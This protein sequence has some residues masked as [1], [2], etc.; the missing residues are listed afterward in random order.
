MQ[1]YYNMNLAWK[2]Q[3]KTSFRYILSSRKEKEA[4]LVQ[5]G[6]NSHNYNQQNNINAE[7]S[8]ESK[9]D[10]HQKIIKDSTRKMMQPEIDGPRFKELKIN[11]LGN[12]VLK[13][14]NGILKVR[15]CFVHL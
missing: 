3:E 13:S 12:C 11:N 14:N 1:Q 4:L 8:T 5:I 7:V 15:G 2:R 9:L 10:E 6:S